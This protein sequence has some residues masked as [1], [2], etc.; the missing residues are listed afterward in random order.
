MRDSG[1]EWT[2]IKY[3]VTPCCYVLFHITEQHQIP[4]R[5][6]VTP[7]TNFFTALLHHTI[8]HNSTL[9]CTTPRYAPLHCTTLSHSIVKVNN[10]LLPKFQF[11]LQLQLEVPGVVSVNASVLHI[12]YRQNRAKSQRLLDAR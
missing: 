1:A 6:K 4:P 9:H 11:Q 3:Y 12:L 5:K 7:I 8:P 2:S 10:T